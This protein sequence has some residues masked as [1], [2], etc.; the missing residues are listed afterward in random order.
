MRIGVVLPGTADPVTIKWY[1]DIG[2]TKT[3]K[4]A[5][6][7]SIDPLYVLDPPTSAVF[8]TEA[9]LGKS[10]GITYADASG[11]GQ[12]TTIEVIPHWIPENGRVR[13]AAVPILGKVA[14]GQA[15]AFQDPWSDVTGKRP[16]MAWIFWSSSRNG[17]SDIYFETISPS[18]FATAGQ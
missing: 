16:D 3:V 2:K 6:Y 15:W 13:E 18:F 7:Y 5:G 10:Y 1:S 17:A 4:P 8:F 9:D 14:E 12:A 11:G